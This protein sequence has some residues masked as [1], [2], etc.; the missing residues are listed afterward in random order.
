[1]VVMSMLISALVIIDLLLT[2]SCG[3]LLLCTRM[4]YIAHFVNAI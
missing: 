3:A 1:M 4:L 2:G